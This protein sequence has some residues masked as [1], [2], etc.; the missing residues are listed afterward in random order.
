MPAKNK[1]TAAPV[2]AK[3]DAKKPRVDPK[4]AP[5]T[6]AISKVENM[7]EK[8]KEM[9]IA[10]FAPSLK[11]GPSSER[12][13][14]QTAA[15]GMIEETLQQEKARMQ[16]RVSASEEK[17]A[18]LN[19]IKTEKDG[20]Q[21]AAEAVLAARKEQEQTQKTLLADATTAQRSAEQTLAAALEAQKQ[22]DTTFEANKQEKEVLDKAFIEHYK[23][24][25]DADE[26]PH[27]G[28]L[29]PLLG[30]LT[31]DESL[32]SALPSS[33]V[34]LK[35]QRGSFDIVVLSELEKAFSTKI[36]ELASLLEAEEPAAADRKAKYEAAESDYVQ[37]KDAQKEAVSAYEAAQKAVKEAEQEKAKA[38]KVA[39]SAGDDVQVEVQVCEV[40][41]Q[42]LS[43][44]EAGPMATFSSL[45]EPPSAPTLDK[46]EAAEEVATAGA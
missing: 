42:H 44:F 39:A 46:V 9:L 3:E 1:R 20:E 40:H 37:K 2:A 10:M 15:L 24:P 30:K 36:A 33:C 12:H 21:A 23:T 29:Q 43:E 14:I 32:L 25:M 31:L 26:G 45:K 8:C 35:D 17:L 16:E 18:N 6:S 38:V 13:E 34:K 27:F 11:V 5:V 19:S 22:G 41:K 28:S 7:P 4:L